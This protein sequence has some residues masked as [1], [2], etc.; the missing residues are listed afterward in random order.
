MEAGVNAVS[1]IILNGRYLISGAQPAEGWT[2]NMAPH[3]WRHVP[4][5]LYSLTPIFSINARACTSTAL[6]A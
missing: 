6:M 3:T 1:G 2:I 4:C 5:G